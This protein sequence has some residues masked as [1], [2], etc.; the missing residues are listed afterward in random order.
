MAL[1]HKHIL[2]GNWCLWKTPTPYGPWLVFS[3]NQIISYKL[4]EFIAEICS[5]NKATTNQ[6]ND[7]LS[8]FVFESTESSFSLAY[9]F[10][11]KRMAKITR[12]AKK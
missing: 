12:E 8:I 5:C 7:S 9:A 10:R 1:S 2:F 11:I 4:D 6:K 3:T